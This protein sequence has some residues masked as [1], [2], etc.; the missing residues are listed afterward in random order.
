MLSADALSESACAERRQRLPWKVFAEL[1]RRLLARSPRPGVRRRV[2]GED[3]DCSRW[4]A[5]SLTNTPQNLAALPKAKSRRGQAAFGKIVTG[6]LLEVGLH[7]PL[8]A[9]IGQQGQSEWTLAHSLL[10]ARC[11]WES[12]C[13]VPAFLGTGATACFGTEENPRTPTRVR[14]YRIFG[15]AEPLK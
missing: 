11:R 5:R 4:M 9:A 13:R 12:A 1:I 7:N 6:V 2:F 15:S 10:A 3:G 14:A 8:A